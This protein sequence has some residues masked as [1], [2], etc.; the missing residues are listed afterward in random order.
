VEI[1]EMFTVELDSLTNPRY[2]INFPTKKHWRDT[3]YL[4]YIERGLD[5]LVGEVERLELESIA[6]PPLGSGGGGLSWGREVRPLIE[7]AL[8]RVPEVEAYVYEPSEE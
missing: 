4:E 8:S 7:E 6:I 5:S 3:T 1:G 2:I